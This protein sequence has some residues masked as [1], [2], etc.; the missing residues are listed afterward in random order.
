MH[1]YFWIY[2]NRRNKNSLSLNL[3]SYTI[4]INGWAYKLLLLLKEPVIFGIKLHYLVQFYLSS[5]P[6]DAQKLGKI[7]RQHWEI[8]NR[9]HWVLDMN[10]D[11]DACRIRSGHG[12][13]NIALIRRL[14]LN[15]LRQETTLKR[16]LRQK[17]ASSCDG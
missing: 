5:L 14:A 6:P 3:T 16:S 12:P 11:E 8:E 13:H 17:H 9:V 2:R 4:E 10:F 7:I 1:K 15:M